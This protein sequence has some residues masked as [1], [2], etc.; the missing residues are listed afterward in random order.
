MHGLDGEIDM[1]K[2]GGLRA[3]MPVTATMFVIGALA[4]AGVPPLAGFFA[5]DQIVNY[6]SERGRTTA[7]VLAWR[8]RCCPRS[9]FRPVFLTFFG[10]SAR[11]PT[12][13]RRRR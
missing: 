10:R 6:A 2:M 1:R 5:K 11:G 7:Y 8:A 3:E 13:T 9:T 12:P 4:L